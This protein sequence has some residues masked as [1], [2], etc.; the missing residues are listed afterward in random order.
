MCLKCEVP[1]LAEGE[2][3]RAFGSMVVWV[4][5]SSCEGQTGGGRRLMLSWEGLGTRELRAQRLA[6][7][8]WA[9]DDKGRQKVWVEGAALGQQ[10]RRAQSQLCRALLQAA[11]GVCLLSPSHAKE[12]A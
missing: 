9:K 11:S 5:C 3:P 2:R 12:R 10:W 6:A 1:L 7:V 8:F 4:V